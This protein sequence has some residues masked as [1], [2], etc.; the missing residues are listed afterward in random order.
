MNRDLFL[1]EGRLP[2]EGYWR[3]RESW[4][5]TGCGLKEGV[6]NE[7]KADSGHRLFEW[8]WNQRHQGAW[9]GERGREKLSQ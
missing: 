5:V 8:L 9:W 2:E 7:K 1:E 6:S 3:R 4:N